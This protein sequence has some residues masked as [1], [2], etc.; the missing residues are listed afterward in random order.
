MTKI[1]RREVKD[2]ES[3]KVVG[4]RR[5]SFNLHL[6]VPSSFPALTVVV[7]FMQKY[8]KLNVNKTHCNMN[9]LKN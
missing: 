7:I 1:N 6:I 3:S 2:L 4:L 5:S 9:V 8:Q